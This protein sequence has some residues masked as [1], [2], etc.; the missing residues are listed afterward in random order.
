MLSLA[1]PM[2]G[3]APLIEIDALASLAVA[4]SA[5]VVPRNDVVPV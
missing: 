4:L 5:V 2:T 1:E 3:V